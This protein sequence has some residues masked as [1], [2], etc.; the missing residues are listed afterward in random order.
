MGSTTTRSDQQQQNALGD[1]VMKVKPSSPT[2][3]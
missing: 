3:F 1:G 2:I